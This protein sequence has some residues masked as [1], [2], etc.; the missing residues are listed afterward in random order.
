MLFCK[1]PDPDP[2][3]WLMD[4]DPGGPKTWSG[5]GF[6]TLYK[7]IVYNPPTQFHAA[8]VEVPRLIRI[9]QGVKLDLQRHA[10]IYLPNYMR[11][12]LKSSGWSGAWNKMTFKNSVCDLPSQ[13]LTL[14]EVPWLIRIKQA[15]KLGMVW[16]YKDTLWSTYPIPWGFG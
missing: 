11:L 8:L 2:Y 12:W 6:P 10:I 14:G 4:P 3:L 5:S 1:D 7:N 15:V 13:L 16:V 9:N